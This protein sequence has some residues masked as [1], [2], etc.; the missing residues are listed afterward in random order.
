MADTLVDSNTAPQQGTLRCIWGPY[1]SDISKGVFIYVDNDNPIEDDRLAVAARTTDKG[2]NWTIGITMATNSEGALTINIACWF[3]LETP[4]DDGTLLHC[5][6]IDDDEGDMQYRSIDVADGTVG[7]IRTVEEGTAETVSARGTI[8]KLQNGRLIGL[9]FDGSTKKHAFKSAETTAPYFAS[10]ETEIAVPTLGANIDF[11]M[12]P[13]TVDDGDAACLWWNGGT[14]IISIKMY[15][16]SENDWTDTEILTSMVGDFFLSPTWHWDAAMRVSDFLIMGAAH[17]S[18]DTA[19]D[20]LKTF[21]A[22]P[23]NIDTPTVAT[24]ANIFTDQDDSALCLVHIDQ[25]TNNVRVGYV[26]GGTFGS[27]VDLVFHLSTD[28]MAT[29]GAEQDYSDATAANLRGIGSGRT[30][31]AHGGRFQP[32]W[33]ND[34]VN[35]VFIN[36]PNDIELIPLPPIHV[37]A[38][39]VPLPVEVASY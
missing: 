15:D 3:D 27:S 6:F 34:T 26:K 17:S 24:T 11:M 31:S 12:Y 21:T 4:G 37:N 22:L 25:N 14:Q 2:E 13:A 38:D 1:Y 9:F 23:N 20:D 32:A 10:A 7:T 8:T 19:G 16:D 28:G 5:V 39:P 36:E 29:W 33:F 30:A 35:D 18:G